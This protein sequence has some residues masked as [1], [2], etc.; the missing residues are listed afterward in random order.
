MTMTLIRAAGLGLLLAA[1]PVLAQTPPAAKTEAGIMQRDRHGDRMGGRMFAS[2]SEAGR[3]TMMEA[4]KAS[5][6]R[7]ERTEVRAARDR[8]LT[9][10]EADRLDMAAL[11]KAMDDERAI[12]A[13][14]HERRQAAMLAGFSKLSVEDRKAFVA[15]ARAMREK[16]QE[17][18]QGRMGERM[19]RW[20][21]R[22]GS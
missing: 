1:S 11:K 7:A 20:R 6:W 13:A 3:A 4:M 18:M 14:S 8:M 22:R 19:Q 21:E 17:R 2:L 9:I 12:S 15:D 16:M 10:L 5:D